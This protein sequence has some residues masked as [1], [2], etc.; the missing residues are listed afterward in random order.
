[1]LALVLSIRVASAY[2]ATTFPEVEGSA[3][4]AVAAVVAAAGDSNVQKQRVQLP[5]GDTTLMAPNR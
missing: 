2:L 4:M 3:V 5:G 1:M